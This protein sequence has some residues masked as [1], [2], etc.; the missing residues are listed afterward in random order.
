MSG[1]GTMRGRGNSDAAPAA[2][3]AVTGVTGNKA[4]LNGVKE[5]GESHP[6][7]KADTPPFDEK[8]L[9]VRY[10]P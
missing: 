10:V 9:D 8:C 1:E 3:S 7:T 4:T 2:A 6:A 5:D